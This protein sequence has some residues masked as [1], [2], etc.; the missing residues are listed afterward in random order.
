M[1]ASVLKC[2]DPYVTPSS[3]DPY[4]L[5][6]CFVADDT[7]V[8]VVFADAMGAPFGDPEE[9]VNRT[10]NLYYKGAKPTKS[11]EWLRSASGRLIFDGLIDRSFDTFEDAYAAAKKLCNEGYEIKAFRKRRGIGISP[12]ETQKKD[13]L[14]RENLLKHRQPIV[15][16]ATIAAEGASCP[17][18]TSDVVLNLENRQDAIENAGYGPMNPAEP[19]EDFWNSKAEKWNITADEAKTS[20]CGNCAAFIITPRM[21]DCIAEGLGGGSAGNS[22]W[23]TIDAGELGYCEAFDFKCASARTCNA[24]ISGGPIT[25]EKKDN[26]S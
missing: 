23:S 6:Y 26:G 14:S 3:T 24:W 7:K 15:A 19:N 5:L 17:A 16:A 10:V 12:Y 8:T 9:Y 22:A 13:P 2:Y 18:A 21:K 11:D 1:A 4:N 20:R 25:E